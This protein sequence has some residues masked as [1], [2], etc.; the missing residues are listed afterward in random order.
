MLPTFEVGA[1]RLRPVR[2][3][4]AGPLR[5]HWDHPDVR[6][7]LFDGCRV[8]DEEA[9]VRVAASLA[10]A[11]RA[12][13]GMWVI[14][15]PPAVGTAGDDVSLVGMCA[16]WASSQPSVASVEVVYSLAP[17]Y[18]GRGLATAAAGAVVAHGLGPL[19]LPAIGAAVDVGNVASTAVLRRLGMV[20][21]PDA[22]EVGPLGAIHWWRRTA[23]GAGPA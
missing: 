3:E 19:G 22:D 2:V 21:V 11:D 5:R 23:G 7:F 18:W 13:R 16:L 6:R 10:D 4:D 17:T 14:D 12:S 15:E 20:R 1:H 9:E 8:S